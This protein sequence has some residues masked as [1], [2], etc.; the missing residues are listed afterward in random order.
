MKRVFVTGNAGAGKSTLANFLGKALALPVYSLDQIVWQPDWRKTPKEQKRQRIDELIR[1]SDKWVIEGVSQIVME[2]ADTIV[3]LDV[4]RHVCLWRCLKRNIHFLFR[5]RPDLPDRCPELL[6]FP[7]LIRIIWNFPTNVRPS[8]MKHLRETEH[9][10]T[11]SILENYTDVEHVLFLMRQAS[12]GSQ[13]PEL[14]A[15]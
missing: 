2:A 9:N 15:E 4:P 5:S 7:E 13:K 11:V 1:S 14:S 8:I 12:R 10:Q 6:I 3:F